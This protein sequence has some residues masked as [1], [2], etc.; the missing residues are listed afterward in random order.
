MSG[1][2]KPADF[3]SSKKAY[4]RN[5]HMLNDYNEIYNTNMYLN[6][7]TSAEVQRLR[8][9]L[10]RMRST[11]LRMK[12]DYLL[13]KFAVHELDF[14]TKVLSVVSFFVFAFVILLTMYM[15]GKITYMYL[16]SI[17]GIISLLLVVMVIIVV[18]INNKRK[19]TNWYQFNWD[20]IKEKKPKRTW[21]EWWNGESTCSG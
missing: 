5:T 11:K 12:Q 4:L 10:D 6:D 9:V 2:N 14:N 20:P 17:I 19:E 18:M 16:F 13:K 1:A 3:E 7:K 21:S 8:G 15:Q